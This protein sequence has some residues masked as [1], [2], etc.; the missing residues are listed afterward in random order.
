MKKYEK[1]TKFDRKCSYGCDQYANYQ[2]NEMKF[3]CADH[4]KKC[5]GVRKRF[6]KTMNEI[7]PNTNFTR[8]Q[9]R[10]IKSA[11]TFQK[12]EENGMTK[13]M[14]KNNKT[15]ITRQKI[16]KDGLTGFERGGKKVSEFRNKIDVETGMTNA[17][18]LSIKG[19]ETR[20]NTIDPE[21]GLSITKLIGKKSTITKNKIDSETGLTSHQINS[22][23]A[24]N[25]MKNQIDPVT[26]K[27]KLQLRSEKI[28]NI[29]NKKDPITGL[30][31][32]ERGLLRSRKLQYYKNSNIL[33]Q[34]KYEY[35]FLEYLE[36]E[37]GFNWISENIKRGDVILYFDPITQRKRKYYPDYTWIEN[38]QRIIVEV[39]STWYWDKNGR[40][41]ITKIK[42]FYKLL[43]AENLGYKVFLCL[44]SKLIENWKTL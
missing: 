4:F 26:G 36:K 17:K 39:K 34:G 13:A 16:G 22:K 43:Y 41:L 32:L 12:I 19:V 28:I 35:N 42:N 23:K 5:P 33:F 44:N 38:N 6:N 7:D 24:M 10:N 14:N 9:N 11:N 1:Y 29:I 18:R 30:S 8:N 37:R 27:N 2:L 31:P 15:K 3:C 21:T 20:M 40:S 25:A